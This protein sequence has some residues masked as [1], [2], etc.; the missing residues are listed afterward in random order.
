MSSAWEK[1]SKSGKTLRGL[2]YDTKVGSG[3]RNTMQTISKSKAWKWVSRIQDGLEGAS[4]LGKKLIKWGGKGIRIAGWTTT[5]AT[6]GYSGV[7]AYNDPNNK[8]T[9]QN[10]GHSVVHAGVDTIKNA[11][12]LEATVIGVKF[13]PIGAGVGFI[14]G[15]ANA[16]FGIINPEG[17]DKFYKGL[18]ED[19]DKFVDGVVQKAKDF[20]NAVSSGWKT[21]TSFFG[22]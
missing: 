10:F 2:L 3:I 13:G 16:I 14:A 19:V 12:P 6:A 20:G 17:K 7:T 9:Y 5:I 22:G 1:Y 4:D 11:G 8:L 18:E 21:V 15:T